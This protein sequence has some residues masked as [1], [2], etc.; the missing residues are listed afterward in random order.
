MVSMTHLKQKKNVLCL[1]K[2]PFKYCFALILLRHKLSVHRA[3]FMALT[4]DFQDVTYN[5]GHPI[6]LPNTVDATHLLFSN[7]NR[8]CE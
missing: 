6:K 3:K 2:I 1:H 8:S 5:F 7:V 4:G